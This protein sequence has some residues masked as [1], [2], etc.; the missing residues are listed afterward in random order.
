MAISVI[1][2]VLWPLAVALTFV[3]VLYAN[4]GM[5]E[6]PEVPKTGGTHEEH[7]VPEIVAKALLC[8]NNKYI[9][10]SCEESYRLNE[11][12]NLDVA[13]EHTDE[14]CTGACLTE[15]NLVLGCIENIF[16]NFL[17][18]NK[19]TIQDVRDTVKAACGN[20]EE[21]GKFN[22]AEHIQAEA[23]NAQK[24]ISQIVFGLGLM[25]LGRGLLP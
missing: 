16:S 4:L 21:R 1:I 2:R 6:E 22:V 25:V 23:S 12:G 17:F 20:G 3:S 7:D 14:Y 9:Y 24:T 11:S 10:S 13:P 19:A 18:Y 8:F 15:T 5:A